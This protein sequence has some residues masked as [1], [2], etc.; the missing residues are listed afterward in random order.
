MIVVNTVIEFENNSETHAYN[1]SINQNPFVPAPIPC[2]PA[3]HYPD[4]NP[5]ATT[6]QRQLRQGDLAGAR[7]PVGQLFRPADDVF[8]Q[9]SLPRHLRNTVRLPSL[10]PEQPPATV[11]RPVDQILPRVDQTDPAKRGHQHRG[12]S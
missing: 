10:W 8:L 11:T 2:D 4:L 7:N 5:S 12:G 1:N 9:V 6:P 3:E